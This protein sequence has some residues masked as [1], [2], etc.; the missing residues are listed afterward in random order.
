M[1]SKF[2]TAL[3]NEL[4]D[5]I[6]ITENGAVGFKTSGKKLVD[7]NFSTSSLRKATDDE[8]TK[9]FSDAFY[10]NKLLAVK[11]L[12]FAR[13]IRGGMGERNIF[14][15]CLKWIASIDEDLAKAS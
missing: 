14:R 5:E 9:K 8:I 1:S 11:W 12:F 13:D 4:N 2:E 15:V 10:E 6:S 7:L 3:K